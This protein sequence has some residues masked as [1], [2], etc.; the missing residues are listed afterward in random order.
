MNN[1]RK[2]SRIVEGSGINPSRFSKG[3]IKFYLY[4][5]PIVLFMLLPIIYI[6]NSAFKPLDELAAFPPRF[7]VTN[8]TFENFKDL[9]MMS[10]SISV[11]ISRYIFNSV[12][13]TAI[14]LAASIVLSTAAGYVLSK[15]PFPGRKLFNTLNT[16]ALM[17]VPVAVAIPRYFIISKTG[18]MDTYLAHVLPLI[19]MPVGLFLVKQF[20][21]QIPDSLIEA[22]KIDGAND[23]H[24]LRSVI[25]PNVKPALATVAILSFQTV[26]N[27]VE[28][29]TLFVD[30]E[31]LKT[32][33]YTLT[34]ITAGGNTVA[35]QGV[36][37]AASLILFLPNLVL[38]IFM[39]SKVMNTL[40]H[41]GIK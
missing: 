22:A 4:L 21:D 24:I 3:Q 41:S 15:R 25:F 5:V 9:G 12:I 28:T 6:V 34:M 23:Y 26:W 39:Q 38:F 29:S 17:F 37:A 18:I 40:V 36:S 31:S 8:P 20:I 13:V 30:N 16:L 27:G 14:V 10:E 32:F 35:G 1:K 2:K 19:S 7:F 11:S 33:A